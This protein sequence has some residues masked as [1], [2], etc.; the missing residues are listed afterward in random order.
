M[1]STVKKTQKQINLAESQRGRGTT[2]IMDL[3]ELEGRGCIGGRQV[4]ERLA[5]ALGAANELAWPE[6]SFVSGNRLRELS[7]H[8]RRHPWIASEEV[9][10]CP[11][12]QTVGSGSS[13]ERK[14]SQKEGEKRTECSALSSRRCIVVRLALA[15]K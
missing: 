7:Y 10:C 9:R 11:P 15:V 4:C 8:A 3:I 1:S 14:A 6:V 12:R 13:Y 5:F 2:E